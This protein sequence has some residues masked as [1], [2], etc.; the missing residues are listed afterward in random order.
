MISDFRDLT[1]KPRL[2]IKY[3]LFPLQRPTRQK[4]T[5]TRIFLL[6][7]KVFFRYKQWEKHGPNYFEYEKH[8]IR[9]IY[10]AGNKDY[11]DFCFTY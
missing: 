1:C 2:I 8:L 6:P 3:C 5:A 9:R 10:D 11:I 4:M 7:N